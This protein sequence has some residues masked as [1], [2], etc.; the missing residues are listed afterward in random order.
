MTLFKW[1]LSPLNI[2]INI[3]KTTRRKLSDVTT[4]NQFPSMQRFLIGIK[5]END[6]KRK[7][8]NLNVITPLLL[9][10]MV[11]MGCS[12]V[13]TSKDKNAS[14]DTYK[15]YSWKE[16]TV[17]SDNSL[18][19]GDLIDQSIRKNVEKELAQK[20]MI[21][22]DENPDVYVKYS[23]FAE[24]KQGYTGSNYYQQPYPSYGYAPMGL[25]Q[26]P[27][28][29]VIPVPAPVVVPP[30]TV[31]TPSSF[32]TPGTVVVPGQ[33]QTYSYGFGNYGHMSG[34]YSPSIYSYT[35]ETLIL[36]F[37]DASTNKIVWRGSIAKDLTDAS[38]LDE[39]MEKGV[40]SI[41]K[42][43]RDDAEDDRNM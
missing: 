37:I 19:K 43:F 38:D 7:I 33:A 35:E 30:G 15:T 3:V 40:H 17:K 28:P 11:L 23:T 24:T 31:E 5:R 9:L 16:P 26:G 22:D 39:Q 2:L 12:S 27:G 34:A 13:N 14:L 25:L 10:L 4:L 8:I 6:M 21:Q 29:I 41:M 32:L 42:K 36:D 1:Y 20:G 18:Y